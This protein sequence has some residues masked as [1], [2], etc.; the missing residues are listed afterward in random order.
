MYLCSYVVQ[1][2][3]RKR[4]W[5]KEKL[6]EILPQPGNFKEVRIPKQERWRSVKICWSMTFFF[7][8]GKFPTQILLNVSRKQKL[9]H[10]S[11]LGLQRLRTVRNMCMWLLLCPFIPSPNLWKQPMD[12]NCRSLF[13]RVSLCSSSVDWYAECGRNNLCQERAQQSVIQ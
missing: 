10:A 12:Q 4:R 9:E 6:G 7:L 2:L 8:P 1:V 11:S 3:C 5:T 13:W